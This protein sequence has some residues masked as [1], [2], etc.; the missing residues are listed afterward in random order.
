MDSAPRGR[1]VSPRPRRVRHRSPGAAGRA[2]SPAPWSVGSGGSGGSGGSRGRTHR[3]RR[4]RSCAPLGPVQGGRAPASQRSLRTRRRRLL[5]R[6]PSLGSASV[7]GAAPRTCPT[8]R[9]PRRAA[10]RKAR[11]VGLPGNAR[12]GTHRA[13]SGSRVERRRSARS[14]LLRHRAPSAQ[15]QVGRYDAHS[16]RAPTRTMGHALILSAERE[17]S[18]APQR[19]CIRPR[20][21]RFEVGFDWPTR[22]TPWSHDELGPS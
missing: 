18:R 7:A 5:P 21:C 17:R 2:R 4:R 20:P 10:H 16:K 13:S 22:C 1:A 12:R 19:T 9:E 15:E 8:A 6:R 14:R 3:A 11:I